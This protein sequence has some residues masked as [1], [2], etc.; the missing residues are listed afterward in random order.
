MIKSLAI[1]NMRL[2]FDI[3]ADNLNRKVTK[4]HCI[5]LRDLD[6]DRDY[7]FGPT[8]I[9]EGLKFLAYA[10]ELWAHN[11]I[12]YDIPVIRELYPDFRP[13]GKV[14][15][16]LIL[17]RL[18]FS[19]I[20]DRDFRGKPAN[21]PANLYGRHSL[22]SWG[23]RL[24]VLKS[25]FGKTLNGDWSTYTP[26]MLDY[27]AKD[28]EV[29]TQ[30]VRLFEPKLQK[31]Q[32]CI[33]IEMRCAK[34]MSRQEYAG[35]PFHTDQAIAL[36][37]K[38]STELETLSD[39]MRSTFTFVDGGEWT[40]KRDNKVSGYV[41]GAA[42]CKIKDFNPTSRE[43]IAWAFKTHRGWE[44]TE[45]TNTGR[46]QID[47]TV[48]DGIGTE[49]AK[50][51]GRIL[52]LQKQ[53]G[54]LSEGSNS[55]LKLVE[56]GRLHHS[57]ML[58]TAT[59]RQAHMRPNLAQVPSAHEFRELFY[60]GPGR[61]LVS[62]DCSGLE[63][64]CLA[65][66]LARYDGGKFGEEVVNGDIHQTM[67]DIS[68]VDRRTQKTIT[69]ALIYG[70]GDT[71]LGLAAGASKG[72]ASRRGKEL[73]SRLLK[74]I[75]GFEA[76]V[77]AVAE[78]AESGVITS[79]DGRPI[80]IRKPHAALNYLLQSCGAVLC[81]SWVIQANELAK[82][83]GIDYYPVE[84]VHDQ[85]SWSVA[86]EYQEQ[87]LFCMTAAIKDVEHEFKFRV[88]LAVDPKSG[89]TWAEVH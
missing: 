61:K 74:G 70:A 43:H 65:H 68:G 30:L 58:N 71:K 25:E 84:F 12:T 89:D 15:D 16:T 18:F 75:E 59:G 63:L 35:F 11:G 80:R 36:L 85:Q 24:G 64:R 8:G 9:S 52:E 69:Y 88:P 81:K 55:W 13:Y 47:E 73:R 62:A 22:E 34:V 82:E 51:F 49:E 83:A 38:L 57:C 31:Y 6:S 20:L 32:R 87:A 78:R 67:A 26:E 2:A 7:R 66:Y 79:L 76:L 14:Y 48:L 17:S 4:I 10:D 19:D 37:S 33:D 21:M 46:A 5:V 72:D 86:P 60:A 1:T 45:F 29:L 77:K 40:P 44:P 39:E 28:V 23:Y 42:C 3:E 27:C 41:K 54:L 50:K 56:N 53:L